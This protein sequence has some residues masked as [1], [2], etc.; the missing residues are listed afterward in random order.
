[1][2][3]EIQLQGWAF[4]EALYESSV[5]NCGAPLELRMFDPKLSD[6]LNEEW[7]ANAVEQYGITESEMRGMIADG[8]LRKWP[9]PSG[10]K[11]FII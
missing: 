5:Q 2:E 7:L 1:M 11:N 3:A 10:G 8:L 6:G 9:G 4:V